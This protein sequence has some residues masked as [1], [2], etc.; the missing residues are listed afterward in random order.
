MLSKAYFLFDRETLRVDG[1]FAALDE[2]TA[3][4]STVF[5]K[6]G[7]LEPLD[8]DSKQPEP[9]ELSWESETACCEEGLRMDGPL[10]G[11]ARRSCI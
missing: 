7:L 9:E 1:L 8:G 6:L 5:I 11:I 10:A 4:V 2:C 3:A